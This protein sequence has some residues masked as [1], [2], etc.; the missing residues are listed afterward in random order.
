[1]ADTRVVR[2]CTM[3]ATAQAHSTLE[4]GPFLKNKVLAPLPRDV[5]RNVLAFFIAC[6]FHSALSGQY[7]LVAFLVCVSLSC[8]CRS[9]FIACLCLVLFVIGLAPLTP[10]TSQS[11]CQLSSSFTDPRQTP[12]SLSM[13][14]MMMIMFF[15]RLREYLKN[16]NHPWPCSN[17]SIA[18]R[19]L[20]E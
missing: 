7:H 3:K 10:I 9:L 11:Q 12:L 1:M 5:D 20:D 15:I 17:T 18:C 6:T 13:I 19:P 4:A 2:T 14:L 8:H 16:L